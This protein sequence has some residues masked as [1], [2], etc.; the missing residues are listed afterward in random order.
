MSAHDLNAAILAL[1]E[2]EV[3]V[4]KALLRADGPV[5]HLYGKPDR[6]DWWD[7]MTPHM[8]DVALA[9]EAAGIWTMPRSPA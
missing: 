7:Y 4:S 3:F 1:L 2:R 6:P 8:Q 9:A 5:A